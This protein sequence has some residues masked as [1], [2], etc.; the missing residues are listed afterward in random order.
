[1]CVVADDMLQTNV[2]W[3]D[4][5]T[6]LQYAGPRSVNQFLKLSIQGVAHRSVPSVDGSTVLSR[7]FAKIN[8]LKYLSVSTILGAITLA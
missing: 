7:S 5:D 3:S 6:K 8:V 4:E 1:M 2:F